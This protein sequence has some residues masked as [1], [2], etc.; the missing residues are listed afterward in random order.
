MPSAA[1]QEVRGLKASELRSLL[2][3]KG[4]D[5]ATSREHLRNLALKYAAKHCFDAEMTD[6][7]L[8]EVEVEA[9]VRGIDLSETSDQPTRVLRTLADTVGKRKV[10]NRQDAQKH[11]APAEELP[12]T[13]RPDLMEGLRDLPPE[14]RIT[15]VAPLY[16]QAKSQS[17]K[18][19]IIAASGLTEHK[20]G[21]I[22]AARDP[23]SDLLDRFDNLVKQLTGNYQ[24]SIWHVIGIG[25]VA[26][27]A[28]KYFYPDNP[29]TDESKPQLADG[30]VKE[31]AEL[32]EAGEAVAQVEPTPQERE[33]A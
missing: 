1:V 19:E 7:Y 24:W 27:A 32:S 21:L 16:K 29:A 20:A 25:G 23:L 33:S 31:P 9:V 13:R 2:Q 11:C 15:L 8:H 30:V 18:D 5:M 22:V 3:F 28:Y 6:E 14:K 17:E 10:R 4:H 12:D 26:V